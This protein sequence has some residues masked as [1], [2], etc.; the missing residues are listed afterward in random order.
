[1]QALVWLEP[2]LASRWREVLK[3]EMDRRARSLGLTTGLAMRHV[4][5]DPLG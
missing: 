4:G 3:K 5:A 2:V 1:M